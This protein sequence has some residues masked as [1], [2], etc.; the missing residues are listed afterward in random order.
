MAIDLTTEQK[1]IGK[2]NFQRVVGRHYEVS[3]R[4]FMKGML[5]AGPVL[6]ISAVAYFGYQT[7][8]GSPVKAGKHVLCEKLMA[9]NITQC[10]EMIKVADETDRILS[11][12]H[13]RH[14]SMLYAHA[15]EELKTGDLG[16]IK[17][18][19]A[20]WHRN[21][22]RPKLD[23]KGNIVKDEKGNPVLRDGWRPDIKKEDR[24]QLEKEIHKHGYKTMEELVRWRLFHRTGGGLMA[25]LGSHQLDACSIFL[26][27][28]RLPDGRLRKK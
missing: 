11:I 8:H 24:D 21:N 3:R 15:V 18:I 6:P 7:L 12:G 4:D 13:Q 20:L 16:D 5:A 19:R 26:G 17:H 9:W 28:V 1:E 2:T 22:A 14:Y 10:K 23:D 27:E 25:E